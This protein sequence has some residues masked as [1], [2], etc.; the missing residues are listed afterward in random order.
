M[1]NSSTSVLSLRV[2]I[3]TVLTLAQIC[4]VRA[5]DGSSASEGSVPWL[6]LIGLLTFGLTASLLKLR[7]VSRSNRQL[8]FEEGERRRTADAL[9]Q[10]E[11]QYEIVNSSASDIISQLNRAE[12]EAKV[13]FEIIH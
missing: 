6:I 12:I 3:A 4:P 7:A 8:L 5:E 11:K 13:I 9:R 2:A 10:S 1:K